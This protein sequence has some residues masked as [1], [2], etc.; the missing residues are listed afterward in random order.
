MQ[1]VSERVML[2]QF[3]LP[4]RFKTKAGVF[5]RQVLVKE[6]SEE[7]YFALPEAPEVV[8]ID[9][10]LTVLAKIKFD[11]PKALLDA[12][13]ADS[14][15]LLGRL[16]AVERLSGQREA[17]GTLQ[18]R[19][20]QDPHYG[21]RMAAAKGLRAIHSDEALDVL[22]AS[23]A[24][25]DAPGFGCRWSTTSRV[26]IARRLMPR[27]SGWPRPSEIR[28]FVPPPSAGSA[29][30]PVP[31][32]IRPSSTCS[33][34]LPII[35]CWPMRPSPPCAARMMRP[36][37]RRSWQLWG[38]GPSFPP[39]S[40]ERALGTLGWLARNEATRDPVREYLLGQLHSKR[41]STRI[42]A[43]SALGTLGD[44]KRSPCWRPSTVSPRNRAR[45]TPPRKR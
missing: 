16:L 12:Q 4:V 21:V 37:S 27:C 35:T 6:K 45:G 38:K 14:S 30:L 24:R 9:P 2:F 33:A 20:N 26:S 8:R 34:P 15:D 28:K 1:K 13:L 22:A 44:R 43:I 23:L 7:F 40:L 32:C 36:S 5:E 3:P 19:L 17:L 25:P 11:P 31:R 10:E 29:L 39:A 41:E 42:A 18:D